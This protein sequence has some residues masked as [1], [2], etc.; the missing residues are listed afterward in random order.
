MNVTWCLGWPE[1]TE[2]GKF[3][4]VDLG[5]TNIRV[6]WIELQGRQGEVVVTQEQYKLSDE[7]KVGEAEPLWDF[8]AESLEAFIST[9]D[10]GGT[11][12]DPLQLG[13]TFSY[14]AHQDY[15]DHGKLVTWTKGFEIKGVEGE[16]VAGQLRESMKKKVS[17]S[18]SIRTRYLHCG[19]ICLFIL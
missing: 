6:C 19:R 11:P 13:F 16:D 17:R 15:I 4:V 2:E 18:D 3:L 1:G 7:I 5:G 12:E 10:L 8:I 14:P 9:H